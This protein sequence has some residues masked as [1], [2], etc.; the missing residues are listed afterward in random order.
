MGWSG[1]KNG[2]LLELA[3]DQFDVFLTSDRNLSFQQTVGQFRIAV[4]VLK[5]PGTQLHQM[6][7]LMPKVLDLLS[8]L[9]PGD[10]LKLEA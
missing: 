10:L 3:Q 8:S 1:L 4:V 2:R 5:A 9:K 6:L 7:P